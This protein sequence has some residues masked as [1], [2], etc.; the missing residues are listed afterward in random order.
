ML[1]DTF[2][3]L[4]EADTGKLNSGLDKA[5]TKAEDLVDTLK[6]ADRQAGKTGESFAGFA[7]KALGALTAAI[8][9]GS[10]ISSSLAR[11]QEITGIANTADALGVAVEELDAFGRAAQAAGGDAQGARD[12][13][14]DMAE[15]IGEAL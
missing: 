14:V 11:A 7:A 1:L 15:T 12:S 5:D 13:L 4:F 2:M 6:N 3:I 9:A 8:S 10:V